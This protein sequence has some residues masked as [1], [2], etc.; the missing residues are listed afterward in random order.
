[1]PFEGATFSHYR[2]LHAIGKG[3][4][5]E[6]YLLEDQRVQ[7]QVAGKFIRLDILQGEPRAAE[8]A[9]RL[10]WREATALAQLDSP[11]ILP[12][13][14]HGE[15]TLAGVDVAYLI[16][17]YRPAGSLKDWLQRRARARQPL[18]LAQVAHLVE[19]AA[20]AL[21]HAHDHCIMHLDVKPG[22]FL[23]RANQT[24]PDLLLSDFGIARLV[25][26]SSHTSQQVHGTPLYTAPEQWSGHAVFA[27]DQYALAIMAYELL[28][29]QPPFR[30]SPMS[31]MYAHTHKQPPNICAANPHL[32]ASV[33]VVL[34]RAL[35]KHPDDR[36]PSVSAFA[37]ALH[38]ALTDVEV[39]ESVAWRSA[40]GSERASGTRFASVRSARSALDELS[41]PPD[42][43]VQFSRF[44]TS[45][46]LT[47]ARTILLTLCALCIVL[48]AGSFGLYRLTHNQPQTPRYTPVSLSASQQPAS[49]TTSSPAS[50]TTATV[51]PAPNVP[52]T[53]WHIQT[54]PVAAQNGTPSTLFGVAWSGK[55]FVAVG[56]NGT[57]LTSPDGVNWTSQK[58]GSTEDFYSVAWS[59]SQ[60]V[61]VGTG[62]TIF[63][64][65]DGITWMSQNS[66][67]TQFLH[68][69][70]WL[71]NQF[72]V[73]GD[74][75]TLLT[76]PD[77]ITWTARPVNTSQILYAVT[78][79]GTRY[80]AV[81]TGGTILTS[82][83]GRV[84]TTQTIGSSQDLHSVV[85][86]GSR[87]VAVGKAGTILT[88][89]DG[90]TWTAPPANTAQ[91]LD[92]VAR[93]SGSQ[94][95]AVGGDGTILT[96]PDGT[97]W[98]PQ[99]AN[100]TQIL[101]GVAWSGTRLVAVGQFGIIL[102][103]P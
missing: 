11:A 15:V 51:Q 55:R 18:S 3:G 20:Q 2:V 43:D 52:G 38:D 101:F 90:S 63:T 88:S 61:A 102:S 59:G 24:F 40:D 54:N 81:G 6:V 21:Q 94:L 80:V 1:M 100:T 85:W 16:M 31:V 25:S 89:P 97:A 71:G 87:F 34:Q 99:Q 35:A 13:Y 93:W 66:H 70:G 36:Y 78:W 76:S 41:D 83:N 84:W 82:T 75:G 7:R 50:R 30:G 65:T 57:I 45:G 42:A 74:L 67:T 72:V 27:S 19:Q 14:D 58:S 37:R 73:L 53:T 46:K 28:A 86:S 33:D 62:G 95:I 44:R 4:M 103:S 32:P 49:T 91:Y 64:S 23:I 5:G 22:N 56:T 26:V 17:P 9:L 47:R 29:G 96:S 77:G 12:L 10:F 98:T 68:A 8:R 60:I 69:V 92:G 48:G 79:S 39:D